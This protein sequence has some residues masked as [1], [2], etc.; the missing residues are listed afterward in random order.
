MGVG[1][2]EKEEGGVR[3]EGSRVVWGAVHALGH[4]SSQLRVGA[5]EARPGGAELEGGALLLAQLH[6]QVE[7]LGISQSIAHRHIGIHAALA[8]LRRHSC[9]R[10]G[11]PLLLVDGDDDVGERRF[12][13][14][15]RCRV[16]QHVAPFEDVQ[17]LQARGGLQAAIPNLTEGGGLIQPRE[18]VADHALAGVLETA[19]EDLAHAARRGRRGVVLHNVNVCDE[20]EN[21]QEKISPRD[22][23]PRRLARSPKKRQ[24]HT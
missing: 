12:V 5:L 15:S 16:D 6:V 14:G 21:V 24:V 3:R 10:R 13:G 23:W 20:G 19:D 11:Q 2:G 18:L 22:G 1:A 9:R 8:S 4:I 7:A 17:G